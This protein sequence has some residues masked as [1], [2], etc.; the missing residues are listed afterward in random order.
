MTKYLYHYY[1]KAQLVDSGSATF[2]GV[3]TWDNKIDE[4]GY[5]KIK[6]MITDHIAETFG[7]Q[8]SIYIERLAFLHEI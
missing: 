4:D 5:N 3:I 1:G 6:K 7:E 2:D 8:R